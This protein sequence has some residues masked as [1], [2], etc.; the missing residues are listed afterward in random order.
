MS[1]LKLDILWSPNQEDRFITFGTDLRLYQV[2]S[3]DGNQKPSAI[4]I[5]E[6]TMAV[7]LSVN[8][9]NQYM[10]CV[11]W[12]PKPDLCNLLAV[13]LENGKAVLTS[14][15][16]V[17]LADHL[18]R[19]F[20]PRHTRPCNSI[21]W[22]PVECNLLAAGLEKYRTDYAIIVW[23]VTKS[24]SFQISVSGDGF[25]FP[26][27]RQAFGNM[28]HDHAFQ[29]SSRAVVELGL[30][31]T[32][33]SLQWFG[34]Q[35]KTLVC[36]MNNK[37]LKIFDLRDTSKHH[38]VTTTKAVYGVCVDPFFEHRLAS[39]VENQVV[40]WDVRNFEKPVITLQEVRHIAKVAW[41]PT[42]NSTLSSLARE[43]SFIKM[44]NIQQV[45]I[46]SDEIEP[47]IVEHSV[48]P[49][50]QHSLSS[51]AW[52]P[53][54]E[55]RMLT[56]THSGHVGDCTVFDRI[57][58]NWSP[59]S[60][61]V[62]TQGRRLLQ[63]VDSRDKF[64]D[65]LNDLSIKMRQRAILDY[66]LKMEQ[67]WQNGELVEDPVL[68]RLWSW[69]DIM[70][71]L[72]E[73]GKLKSVVKT[74]VKY[75]GVLTV[76]GGSSHTTSKT[77]QIALSSSSCSSIENVN[78]FGTSHRITKYS[79]E[80]RD[81]ALQLCGWG[82]PSDRTSLAFLLDR[83]QADKHF[84][85]ASMIAVFNLDIRSAIQILKKGAL[86][87]SSLGK[88]SNLNIV[89]MALSGYSEDDNTLW[90]ETCG[91]IRSQLKNPYLRAMFA[92]L[93]SEN[94]NYDEVLK[95]NDVAVQDRVAFACIFLSDNKLM[96]FLT[97][98]TETMTEKGYLDGILLTGLTVDCLPLIQKYVDL[99]GD[100]QTAS[101]VI[102]HT[103]PSNLSQDQRAQSWVESYQQ[104]L[105]RWRLWHQ[106]AVFDIEWYKANPSSKPPPHVFVSC[107]FCGKSVS[108]YLQMLGQGHCSRPLARLAIPAANKSKTSCCPG[109]RKPLPRC[110][111]C[112]TN[113]GTPSGS[114]WR[115]TTDGK[116]EMK[117]KKLSKFSSWFTWCQS[118]RHGGH[119]AHIMEWFIDH[120]ECPVTACNCKCMSLDSVNSG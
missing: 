54:Q 2:I 64:Y 91:K 102:L 107:N 57:T 105:D 83:L 90:G 95:E 13:G 42:R 94:S 99:T 119:S 120:S 65:C 17:N 81:R 29:P 24:P 68:R 69:L 10:K 79:S 49:F 98:L 108:S 62:W 116:I 22:N 110:A 52:H 46:G 114:C 66:G 48:N 113:M 77:E 30:S 112:L 63:C 38:N 118:C 59:T 117:D 75:E 21:A 40:L 56:I 76:I 16:G 115:R 86:V 97:K 19:E 85:R 53:G 27:K 84:E 73:E 47:T 14:F 35:P 100:V 4:N 88:E 106:R 20:V 71:S 33:N 82:R 43:S 103:M 96:E 70:K 23:D 58:L 11:S 51:F 61:I 50:G 60:E 72:W 32:T 34:N 7:L 25:Y 15:N 41:C 26:E 80:E 18:S 45:S 55:N 36:G 8:S 5:S 93:T 109:C 37:F 44:Y 92:F 87:Q 111:L 31:E 6:K 67:L 39:F 12:Y 101:L 3:K 28:M 1:S 74:D 89:A 78:N 104:L 9:D